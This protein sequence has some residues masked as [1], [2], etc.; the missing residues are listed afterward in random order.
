[1]VSTH[2][3]GE[4]VMVLLDQEV[5]GGA[6][7]RSID[8]H[9]ATLAVALPAEQAARAWG[10]TSKSPRVAGGVHDAAVYWYAPKGHDLKYLAPQRLLP[11]GEPLSAAAALFAIGN[12]QTLGPNPLR[13][14]RTEPL[15]GRQP[16][17]LSA[18][19]QSG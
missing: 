3:S 19:G 9:C 8:R 11:T 18:P 2:G 4:R 15:E 5:A 13:R 6:S 12:R 14:K 7:A 10:A 16:P 1:V 17:P